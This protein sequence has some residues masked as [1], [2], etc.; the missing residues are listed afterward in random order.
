[1][2]R[3]GYLSFLIESERNLLN[4]TEAR[5][6]LLKNQKQKRENGGTKIVHY[7]KAKLP[8]SHY[9]GICCVDGAKRQRRNR[10]T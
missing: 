1:M 3:Y 7:P 2:A 4:E 8:S 10:K 6:R 9:R 5:A